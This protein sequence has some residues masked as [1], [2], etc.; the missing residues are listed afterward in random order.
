M[1]SVGRN[2]RGALCPIN[3]YNRKLESYIPFSFVGERNK[4]GVLEF[5]CFTHQQMSK[6]FLKLNHGA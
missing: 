6:L 2:T 5:E 1:Q 3:A 4:G